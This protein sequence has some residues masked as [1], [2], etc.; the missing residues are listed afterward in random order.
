MREL[1]WKIYR[2]ARLSGVAYKQA[3]FFPLIDLLGRRQDGNG[4]KSAG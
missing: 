1:L 4:Q 2:E 3:Q